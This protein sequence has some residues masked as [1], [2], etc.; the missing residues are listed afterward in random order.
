MAPKYGIQSLLCLVCLALGSCSTLGQAHQLISQPISTSGSLRVNPTPVTDQRLGAT[1]PALDRPSTPSAVPGP[2]MPP[3]ET[4]LPTTVPVQPPASPISVADLKNATYSIKDFASA[5]GGSDVF[6]LVDGEYAYLD[7]THPP[8]PSNYTVQYLKSAT[9]D[10][11]GD[12]SE[13]AAVILAADTSGSGTF[14]Y[15]AAMLSIDGILENRDTVYLGDRVVV[16]TI[17][18][19]DGMLALQMITHGPQDPMCCPSVKVD[20]TY[21]LEH[22][23]LVT[24]AQKTVARLAGQV[25]RALSEKD[26]VELAELADPAAG[27]RFSPYANTKESDLVFTPSQLAAAFNDPNVYLWGNYEG[28]GAPIQLTFDEYYGSFVYS[29]DFASAAQVGYNHSISNPN[30]ID[31]SEDF[32]PNAIIVEYYLPGTQPETG[33][34]Q[35]W[36]SLKLVF[37]QAAADGSGVNGPWYLVGIIHSQWTI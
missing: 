2:G 37:M 17:A 32:Y 19:Q 13:D 6:T 18:I 28:S 25:I 34:G 8:D 7:P 23:R 5:N 24:P 26:L 22:D 35:D 31:N 12:G 9:G 14:I 27:V 20:Q 3:A 10:L 4:L 15:L 29:Q 33:A 11:N 36:Q 21:L 16:E 1:S 30:V